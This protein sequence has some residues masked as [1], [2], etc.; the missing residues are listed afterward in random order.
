MQRPLPL[1]VAATLCLIAGPLLADFPTGNPIGAAIPLS[2][3]SVEVEDVLRIPNSSGQAPRLEGL[4]HGGV[5]GLAYVYDQRGAIYTFNP[6]DASPTPTL[7]FNIYSQ[8]QNGNI[9]V[10]TGLRGLAFHPDFNTPGAAGQGKFYTAHSR[11]AFAAAVGSPKFFNSPPGLN[12]DSV[13]GEWSVDPNG[14]VV[15]SS[16]R[17]LIR[18]GQPEN[19]H[20]VGEI[21]F[22]PNAAPG[23]PDYGNLYI[24]LGDGGGVGNPNNTAQNISINAAGSGGKGFPHGSL[25]RVNPLASGGNPFTVPS[26]N[27]FVGQA[28]VIQEVWA[29]GLRNPHNFDWD[30]VTGKML[31][32]DIGQANVE[33]INLGVAG[34]NYGWSVSEG[35]F[36]VVNA[37][38]V[39][40]LPVDHPADP[41]TYPVAQYDHDL[42]NNNQP[43]GLIAVAGGPVY[44]GEALPGLTGR[45]LFG[46]FAQGGALY[47]VGVGDLELRDDLTN[48]GQYSGGHLAPI[49]ELRLTRGGSP[50]TLLAIIRNASQNFGLSRTDVRI[51]AGPDGEVYLLNK[52][53]GMVR[54]LASIT[55]VLPGDF[56][57]DG[58]VDAAD[59]TVW[60]DHVGA[61]SGT[62]PN[63]PEGGVIGQSQYELWR[64]NFAAAAQAATAASVPEP[65]T[66]TLLAAFG[67]IA[68]LGIRRRQAA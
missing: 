13:I 37:N 19:D 1:L 29:Y 20:N 58:A 9:G 8:V 14:V 67:A 42:N 16:Y 12:H 57:N 61:P 51:A 48:V 53:D 17:E 36:R 38:V 32:A 49:S 23:D 28:D 33:E 6:T 4:V 66:A 68:A 31:I 62:L 47:S 46:D 34:A 15:P 2:S 59:Y 54:R 65:A 21:G 64:A 45:Y 25:L 40:N 44:R 43:D 11:N 56:N 41:Y 24:A 55:G 52:H 50:T 10:Q 27:P 35:T 18:V 7:F 39:D 26:D 60:C 5:P 63:D 3:F 30:S 22:N